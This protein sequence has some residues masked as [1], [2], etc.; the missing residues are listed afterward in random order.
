MDGEVWVQQSDTEGLVGDDRAMGMRL[1]FPAAAGWRGAFKLQRFE[2]NFNPALGFVRRTGIDSLDAFVNHQWRPTSG[3]IRTINSG[4]F[5]QSIDYLDNGD[6]QSEEFRLNLVN[7][8]FNSQDSVEFRASRNREGLRLPFEIS[9]GI[10]L[11]PGLYSFDSLNLSVRTGN[12]RTVGA[13]I[14]SDVGEFWNGDQVGVGGFLSFRPNSHFRTNLNYQYNNVEL[15]QGK[16]ITRVLR[17]RIEAVFS[18]TLSWTNLIQYDN[19]S[20]T[21]GFNSRLHWIPQAGR[22]AFLVL[23]HNS[24]DPAGGRDFQ[25]ISS[26]ISL[27]YSYT[28]RF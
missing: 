9:P 2:E 8:E 14:F 15:P 3:P 23:D 22:E 24:R 17:L 27:K 6:I 7:I 12:Q 18:N 21:V 5:Y 11:D 13:G 1:R 19:V 20:N 4:V 16:F 26:D 10:V 25:S 28:F